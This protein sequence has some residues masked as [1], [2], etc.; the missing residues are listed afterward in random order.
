MKIVS[1]I[2]TAS[3]LAAWLEVPLTTVYGWNYTRTG[4]KV[5]KVGR[6][7]RYRRSD[8]E[9]WLASREVRRTA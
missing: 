5:I 7:C 8:V 9:A 6:H 2:I 3:D 4:P 1:E